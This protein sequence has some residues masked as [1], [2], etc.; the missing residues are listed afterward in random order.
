MIEFRNTYL[1]YANGVQALHNINLKIKKSDFV[2]IVGPTGC[3]KSSLLKLIYLEEF[4]T[5]GEIIVNAKKITAIKRS[6]IP[7]HRRMIGVIFQDFKLLPNKTVWQNVSFALEV[8]N[9]TKQE[10]QKQVPK[11]LELVGLTPKINF[12]PDDLSGGEKQRV[13]IARALVHDPPILLADEPTGNLDPDSA[14]EIMNLLL[15]VNSRGTTVVV[16]TH[17]KEAVDSLQQRVVTIINGQIKSDVQ[18][19]IYSINA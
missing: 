17:N 15:A 10:V 9:S 19:G 7:F 11:V 6:R 12:H 8:T 18:Q 13:A 1:T 3:G 5:Q 2:F 16:A 14:K 4:P